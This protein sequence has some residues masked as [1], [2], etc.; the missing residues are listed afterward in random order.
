MLAAR[1]P[2]RQ[3]QVLES[4]F[5]PRAYMFIDRRHGEAQ[6]PLRALVPV[7]KF[8]HRLILARQ[9]LELHFAARIWHPAAVENRAA[10]VPARVFRDAAMKRKTENSHNQIIRIR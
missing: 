8:D 1:A 4:A 6:T 2:E 5:L 7:E 9:R 10:A 3:H